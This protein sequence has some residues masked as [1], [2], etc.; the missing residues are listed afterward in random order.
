[1]Q[2]V[3]QVDGPPLYPRHV[4]FIFTWEV[5]QYLFIHFNGPNSLK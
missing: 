2:L 1:M 4:H 5:I 3:P